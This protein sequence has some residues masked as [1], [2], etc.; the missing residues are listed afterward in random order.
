[1]SVENDEYRCTP[2]VIV[3]SFNRP[4]YFQPVLESLRRQ[5]PEIDANRVHLFQDGAVNAYSG[6]RYAQDGEIAQCIELFRDLFPRGHLHVSERN[7]GICE[8]FLRAE[9]F[10][11]LSLKAPVAY[12]FEDD[13]VVSEHYLAALD[14]LRRSFAAEPRIPYFNAFGSFKSSIEDQRNNSKTLKAMSHL[15]GFGLKRSHWHDMQPRLAPY[16][17]M[18]CGRDYRRRPN[19]AI[20]VLFRNWGV[21]SRATSQDAAKANVTHLLGRWRASTYVCLA[22]Y[23]GE[24]GTHGTSDFYADRGFADTIVFDQTPPE[25]FVIRQAEIDAVL[26][27]K[28]DMYRRR[29]RNTGLFDKWKAWLKVR[30]WLGR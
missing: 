17:N 29:L 20:R 28:D 5:V 15:W 26:S 22:R 13:M 21:P 6:V 18:V 25:R 2:P 14:A 23:I 1:V 8:N 9:H 16:Y 19:K 7:I 11:F 30:R 3:F 24:Q 10:A 12:F 4:Q 27:A